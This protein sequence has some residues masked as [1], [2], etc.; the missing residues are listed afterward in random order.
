MG[1]RRRRRRR[2]NAAGW[3]A[4]LVIL[5]GAGCI[6][7][8]FLGGDASLTEVFSQA[9][10]GDTAF[11]EEAIP[12]ESLEHK[13]YYSQLDEEEQ[14]TYREILQGLESENG[15]IRLH[16]EE[17]GRVN[18]IF[19][20]VLDDS[21][22]VFWCSGS[23]VATAW[24]GTGG[25][26]ASVVLEPEYIHQGEERQQME[27][28]IEAAA[29]A[30]I[31]RISADASEYDRIKAVYE[32][33]IETVDYEEGVADSQNI[34]SAL[35]G[36]ASV[37][38]GYAR[39]TQ[40]LLDRLGV[41]CIY[42]TGTAASGGQEPEDHAWN[43]V[44]CNGN[45]YCVDTTWGDPIFQQ[46][47]ELLAPRDITYDYLC[48]TEEEISRTHTLDRRA[49]YPACTSEDLNYYRL[50]GMFYET[51]DSD[52]LLA[53]MRNSIEGGETSTVFKFSSQELYLEAD[54]S[55]TGGLAGEAARY[56]GTLYGLQEIQYSYEENPDL[57]KI[58]L[59]WSYE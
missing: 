24:P 54:T 28:E 6:A 32:Y 12:E 50:N 53:A 34:Y 58:T 45:W 33:L 16:A 14:E 26:E 23:A 27:A 9:A 1:R 48:C 44:R 7:W 42:V 10:P 15:E 3:L 38:A 35:V 52:T 18:E 4:G 37:C 25:E 13:F 41:F 56:L 5:A 36:H 8:A 11:Q 43:L 59:Y 21:P 39:S 47:E 17:A 20:M 57:W 40:Y 51:S 19:Q 49:D 29:E 30:C 46:E 31:S 2:R 55:L 22:S